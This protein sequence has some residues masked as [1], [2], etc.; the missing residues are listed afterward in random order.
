MTFTV[1]SYCLPESHD[2]KYPKTNMEPTCYN[3]HSLASSQR[4]SQRCEP[5]LGQRGQR[6]VVLN[7]LSLFQDQNGW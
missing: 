2:N 6:S 7:G 1:L 3:G 5:R 4:R